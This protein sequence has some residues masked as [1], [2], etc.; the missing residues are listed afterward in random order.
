MKSKPTGTE[1]RLKRLR[2]RVEREAAIFPKKHDHALL[3]LVEKGNHK[4][5]KTFKQQMNEWEDFLE[6][7]K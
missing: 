4:K 7:T 1:K 5:R 2:K 6:K 3:R